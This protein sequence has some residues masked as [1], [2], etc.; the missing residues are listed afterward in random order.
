MPNYRYNTSDYMRR[1]GCGRP[2]PTPVPIP[3]PAPSCQSAAQLIPEPSCCDDNAEYDEWN[4][5]R[6]GLRSMA[7]VAES[8]RSRKRIS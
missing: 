5:P 7:G 8:L 6:Y 1:N 3:Q 4:A 2:A